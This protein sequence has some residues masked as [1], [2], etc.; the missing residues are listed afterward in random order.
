M[1]EQQTSLTQHLVSSNST[2]NK[3]VNKLAEALEA[4]TTNAF[5]MPSA[6]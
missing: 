4:L 6:G 1:T 3:K 5:G 2:L